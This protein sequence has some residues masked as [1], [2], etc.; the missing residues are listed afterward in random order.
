[1]Y[2]FYLRDYLVYETP[3]IDTAGDWL[4]NS[5]WDLIDF[6]G[7]NVS[8]SLLELTKEVQRN[9]SDRALDKYNKSTPRPLTTPLA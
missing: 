8:D 6:A 2:R 5:D 9:E 1:M 7:E 4:L 3:F